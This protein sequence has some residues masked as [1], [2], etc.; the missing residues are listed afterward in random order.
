MQKIRIIWFRWAK[1][2]RQ[3]TV[4]IANTIA[5]SMALALL[6]KNFFIADHGLVSTWIALQRSSIALFHEHFAC[7]H[8]MKL[9][10]HWLCWSKSLERKSVVHNNYLFKLKGVGEIIFAYQQSTGRNVSYFGCI[11]CVRFTAPTADGNKFFKQASLIHQNDA[12][13]CVSECKW[14]R[15][16][17]IMC[18]QKRVH[19][20]L[21]NWVSFIN[22]EYFIKYI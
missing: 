6:I 3:K 19:I 20:L 21:K 9:L 10:L 14:S 8:K 22:F 18:S 16:K 15:H 1:I 4:S 11:I 5:D 13:K 12:K 7:T 2:Y 17:P